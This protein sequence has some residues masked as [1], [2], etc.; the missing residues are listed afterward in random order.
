MG[1]DHLKFELE[2][3][4]IID[5]W[6]EHGIEVEYNQAHA[7]CE[8]AYIGTANVPAIPQGWGIWDD[9]DWPREPHVRVPTSEQVHAGDNYSWYATRHGYHGDLTF[10]CGI[11]RRWKN[12]SDL[13][14][15]SQ[16]AS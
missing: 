5:E 14:S 9:A 4:A 2:R 1:I 15:G 12:F 10:Q 7:Q 11:A 16:P 3:Q 6:A 13:Q 8:P